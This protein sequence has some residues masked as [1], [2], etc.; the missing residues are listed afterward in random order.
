MN[1]NWNLYLMLKFTKYDFFP[2]RLVMWSFAIPMECPPAGMEPW[3]SG[4]W[5]QEAA[6]G[7]L[8]T[9]FILNIWM[10]A[11]DGLSL[12][13]RTALSLSSPWRT[14]LT[15]VFLS[16]LESSQRS[17]DSLVSGVWTP[18]LGTS[19]LWGWR[20][21]PWSPWSTPG[22]PGIQSRAE[23]LYRSSCQN[24]AIWSGAKISINLHKLLLSSLFDDNILKWV[25]KL[26]CLSII[27]DMCPL[28]N[29]FETKHPKV[30]I[31]VLL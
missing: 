26:G 19:W 21:G 20:R 11:A 30:N 7:L 1:H 10:C 18:T 25:D 3:E 15:P 23:L 27:F 9:D 14:V 12:Q 24:I 31:D 16:P 29:Y 2:K 17:G 13:M 4:T 28:S 6:S 22:T 5:Y 8:S